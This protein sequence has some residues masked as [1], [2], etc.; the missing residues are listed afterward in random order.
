MAEIDNFKLDDL[1]FND[2]DSLDFEFEDPFGE[3]PEDTG[4]N[5]V[6]Q[7]AR[8]TAKAT[9]RNLKDPTQY[10][11]TL[12]KALPSNYR[13][14]WDIADEIKGQ[15]N[16]LYN[17]ALGRAAPAL[18]EVKRGLNK[19]IPALRGK[20][21]KGLV[22]KLEEM[23]T[24][25][26]SEATSVEAE[27]DSQ[28]ASIMAETFSEQ[29][30]RENDRWDAEKV[31][32]A[33]LEKSEKE[34]HI[35]S[36]MLMSAINR[37]MGRTVGY[38]DNVTFKYQRSM[39]DVSYRSLFALRDIIL[40]QQESARNITKQLDA[41]IKNTAL[42]DAVKLKMSEQFGMLGRETMIKRFQDGLGGNL[43]T[44]ISNLGKRL[45]DKAYNMVGG[46]S[47]AV[48]QMSMMASMGGMMSPTAM[49]GEM[50][51][52]L[53]T[54]QLSD[55]AAGH[56]TA[57]RKGNNLLRNSNAA[58]GRQISNAP[59]ALAEFARTD[60]NEVD[61]AKRKWYHGSTDDY[62]VDGE[63]NYVE[64]SLM[65]KAKGGV[66]GFLRSLLNES[67][68]KDG[69][70]KADGGAN[71]MDPVS[72]NRRGLMALTDVIPGLLSMQ[73]RELTRIRTGD[74]APLMTFDYGRG[75]FETKKESKKR[76][77]GNVLNRLDA[78]RNRRNVDDVVTELDHEKKLSKEDRTALSRQLL[79]N[80]RNRRSLVVDVLGDAKNYQAIEDEAT[81]DRL[82][83]FFKENYGDTTGFA[84]DPERNVRMRKA[85]D[86]YARLGSLIP[87]MLDELELQMNLGN[88]ELLR[89]MG[90]LIYK[91]NAYSYNHDA[92]ID[93]I[94]ASE[95]GDVEATPEVSSG[96]AAGKLLYDAISAAKKKTKEKVFDPLKA[97]FDQTMEDD[98]VKSVKDY[99]RERTA[100]VVDGVK[101]QWAK[102][103]EALEQQR[104][105]DRT[106]KSIFG[107]IFDK[108][109]KEIKARYNKLSRELSKLLSDGEYRDVVTKARI[110]NIEDIINSV[111]DKWGNI[112]IDAKELNNLIQA[113]LIEAYQR[114][115]VQGAIG[116]AKE[117][118][119]DVLKV[120]R[121]APELKG[122]RDKL[123]S[124]ARTAQEKIGDVK[125]K[126]NEGAKFAQEKTDKVK[127]NISSVS[128]E[129]KSKGFR[130][131]AGEKVNAAQQKIL[132]AL[133][134]VDLGKLRDKVKDFSSD[135]LAARVKDGDSIIQQLRRQA[136]LKSGAI[137]E[138][139]Q[140]AKSKAG[141]FF[142]NMKESAN[143]F[144]DQHFGNRP[145]TKQPPQV[146][147]EEKEAQ[148]RQD[149]IYDVI[150]Q[151]LAVQRE[152]LEDQRTIIKVLEAGVFVNADTGEKMGRMR[153]AFG[154]GWDMLKGVRSLTGGV[155]RGLGSAAKGAGFLVGKLGVG[156]GKLF[157]AGLGLASAGVGLASRI[158]RNTLGLKND[159]FVEGK[160]YPVL[161]WKGIKEG[162]YQDLTTGKIIKKLSDIK[163]PVKNLKTNEPAITEEDF[164]KGLYD[165][166]GKPVLRNVLRKIGSIYGA[167]LSPIAT[168]LR[169]GANA[170]KATM[171]K[172]FEMKDVYTKKDMETPKLYGSIM[173][174]GGYFSKK[175]GRV[176][177]HYRDLDGEIVDQDRQVVL[178]LQDFRDGLCDVNGKPLKTIA[179][180]ILGVAGTAIGLGKSLV[181]GSVK[182]G[183]KAMRGIFNLGKGL[184]NAVRKKINI[185]FGSIEEANYAAN[186]ETN[187]LLEAIYGL[188]DERLPGKKIFGDNDGDGVK[189]GSVTDILRRRKA[190]KD[191]QAAQ[192]KEK[193]E[194]KGG[195]WMSKLSGLFGGLM[196]KKNDEEDEGDDGDTIIGGIGGGDGGDEA[197]KKKKGKN[198]PKKG[199]FGKLGKWWQA[200]KNSRVGG[201]LGRFGGGLAGAGSRMLGRAAVGAGI[202]AIGGSLLGMGGLGAGIGGALAIV[203]GILASPWVLGA[204]VVGAVGYGAYKLYKELKNAPLRDYR[205]LQ[206]GLVSLNG[207]QISAIEKLEAYMAKFVSIEGETA[208]L[209]VSKEDITAAAE[210][211]GIQE[212]H[213]EEFIIWFVGRFKPV[214]LNYMAAIRTL[215]PNSVITDIDSSAFTPEM[216]LKL[217]DMVEIPSSVHG[218]YA[219]RESPF[220]KET[221]LYSEST[222]FAKAEELR[223]LYKKDVKEKEKDTGVPVVLPEPAN[224][225]RAGD[226]LAPT[227]ASAA[228]ATA[229]ENKQRSMRRVGMMTMGMGGIAYGAPSITETK[230]PAANS[231]S[232]KGSSEAL[233]DS[234]NA[235]NQLEVIRLKAYGLVELDALKV[236]QLLKMERELYGDVIYENQKAV[237]KMDGTAALERFG[238]SFG[239]SLGDEKLAGT[240]LRWFNYRFVRVF[241]DFCTSAHQYNENQS[242]MDASKSFQPEQLLT[243]AN[244]ILSAKTA[245]WFGRS[246]WSIGDSPWSGYALNM[247]A[248]S[249]K[250][251]LQSIEHG[252]SLRKFNDNVRMFTKLALPEALQTP[253]IKGTDKS[254]AP[255]LKPTTAPSGT[256]R[257][258]D[259]LLTRTQ[260]RV[261]MTDTMTSQRHMSM[262]VY[263]MP[264]QG[265][266]S[267]DYGTRIHPITGQ[268]SDHKG[269]DI[270][271]PNGTP[272]IAAQDGVIARRD[273]STSYGN[274]IYMDHPDGNSTRYAHLQN[275]AQGHSVGSQISRGEIIGYVGNTGKSAGNHL[276]F[277][278]RK[279]HGANG[280]PM[281]PM[282]FLSDRFAKDA[283]KE[284]QETKKDLKAEDKVN[285]D[286]T[287]G[288]DTIASTENKTSEP[289]AALPKDKVN[290]SIDLPNV[291]KRTPLA[292]MR[293]SSPSVAP[294]AMAPTTEAAFNSA[295]ASYKQ[296]QQERTAAST[297][298]NRVIS[299]ESSSHQREMMKLAQQ[300]L[301]ELKGINSGVKE[302]GGLLKS[303]LEAQAPS[304]STPGP[305]RSGTAD[306]VNFRKK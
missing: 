70:E 6:Y 41:V 297:E 92:I 289:E 24:S 189:E 298:A 179:D 242:P 11:R 204:L 303:F 35:E 51:G 222:I 1:E 121:E 50:G 177:K 28:I 175:T 56:L 94:M 48:E 31:R 241:L 49:A 42:P 73:L 153:T 215:K 55:A 196:S 47:D 142:S 64:N 290:F 150:E 277:E 182:A 254:V 211:M 155:M 195:G 107:E 79:H 158:T 138:G 103:G 25:H 266:I 62:V 192:E 161:H 279:G 12:R 181:V 226:M 176:I 100:P 220:G 216:K 34:R 116:T 54:D 149:H 40:T 212:Q 91:D 299:Q 225:V 207:D 88:S 105:S 143:S 97:K 206:Y 272:V 276:H 46:I 85:T 237:L 255:L 202:G 163:G 208:N 19:V 53:I 157:G 18:K 130:E 7:V 120:Y 224:T 76:I 227:A 261:I 280:V 72:L 200:A 81:R 217:L 248:S 302:M 87:S 287:E 173:K 267:S 262:G 184:F 118:M 30:K 201:A 304:K 294:D 134:D 156:Y 191:N 95:V 165:T 235:P 183:W 68:E 20:L 133:S 203:G 39:L 214:F 129:I 86:N 171:G 197:D 108:S 131:V 69:L 132:D 178:T 257:D 57:F 36:L 26:E 286:M 21:P 29:V 32:A 293:D 65:G 106:I 268:K 127:D 8:A 66:L 146:S 93:F 135:Q 74:D 71:L 96:A 124:G 162:I 174:A 295:P 5:P 148:K 229:E 249:A 288:T 89:K 140:D 250:G 300:S 80:N 37:K 139:L 292:N 232:Y 16:E 123:D 274:V 43:S 253:A 244:A 218:P 194:A 170:Y 285:D 33:V 259:N 119:D 283:L 137:V 115:D 113:T 23:S 275:F 260:G 99:M 199:K 45:S 101:E 186:N 190:A 77:E 14:A 172:I 296:R 141:G 168:T 281:D 251:N 128:E 231:A 167:A 305:N 239:V 185:N 44:V 10:I 193:A 278:V 273:Y 284:L 4:R 256:G 112:V 84:G 301:S 209:R 210:E 234:K 90:F 102:A 264:C 17:R 252:V 58:L 125:E 291:G 13:R 205:I 61:P 198:K 59:Y 233:T 247:D 111:E 246:I 83:A 169:F 152:A 22:D 145:V 52:S 63:G 265:R 238:A 271:A 236:G 2:F 27:R 243:I 78:K 269:I 60:P 126:F 109:S 258:N 75:I 180:R 223:K 159:I 15:G 213:L 245:N 122:V 104:R 110:K 187:M 160:P 230:R 3:P 282:K 240:W 38:Q 263:A 144:Y 147:F 151:I 188:L 270:A 98:R 9:A 306:V 219:T 82:A 117:K 114:P 221:V 166:A 228:A 164:K 154:K 67:L 136:D